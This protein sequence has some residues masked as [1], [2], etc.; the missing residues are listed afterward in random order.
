MIDVVFRADGGAA[1]GAGH[2]MRC[3]ALAEVCAASG[4][5]CTLVSA[6]ESRLHEAWHRKGMAVQTL[7]M[8]PGGEADMNFM[9][10]TAMT[11]NATWIVVDGYRLAESYLEQL[12]MSDHL[13]LYLDD[14]GNRDVCADLVLNQNVGAETRYAG[15]YSRAK[16]VL[17]GAEYFLVR[18]E[19]RQQYRTPE[20]NRVLVTFGGDDRDNLA[21]EFMHLLLETGCEFQADVICTA[22]EEGYEQ[23]MQLAAAN[24]DRFKVYRGGCE[25]A[26]LL[27]QAAVLACA[28]G[29]TVCEAACLG[30]PSVITVL[31][32]NQ[33]PGAK[34]L[35]DRGAAMIA[36]IGRQALPAAATCVMSL[37]AD[38]IRCSMLG[39]EGRR[40]IDGNGADRVVVAMRETMAVSR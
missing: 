14:L 5:R 24:P 15:S 39:D 12:A 30:V 17:L 33:L 8:E 36:G 32:E 23:A 11:L 10:S 7:G 6:I 22:P 38:S 21:M 27:G 16:R 40:A 31:A 26:P 20:E 1:V 34:A 13:L 3:L 9:L 25:I 4:W 2:L 37:L 19:I 28:G 29:V 18:S 35:A